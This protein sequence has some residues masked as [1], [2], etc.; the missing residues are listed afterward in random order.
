MMG[1]APMRYELSVRPLRERS[2]LGV[3]R[4]WNGERGVLWVFALVWLLTKA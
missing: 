3:G 2:H 1:K 4:W